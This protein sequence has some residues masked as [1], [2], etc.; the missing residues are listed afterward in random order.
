MFGEPGNKAGFPDPYVEES[1]IGYL[2][3][4]IGVVKAGFP[5]P[6]VEE[7]YNFTTCPLLSLSRCL[8][9]LSAH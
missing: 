7:S 5:D 9:A 8:S 4:L 2:E 1:L 3:V 6:Y